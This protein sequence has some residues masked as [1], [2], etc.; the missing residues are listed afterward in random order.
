MKFR[1]LLLLP[2]KSPT[3]RGAA[4]G[5][6]RTAIAETGRTASQSCHNRIAR[7]SAPCAPAWSDLMNLTPA[8]ILAASMTKSARFL[9][10]PLLILVFAAWSAGVRAED[11]PQFRGP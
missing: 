7:W 5:R 1:R 9:F 3:V 4:P 11:W 6:R 10:L 2:L 8:A